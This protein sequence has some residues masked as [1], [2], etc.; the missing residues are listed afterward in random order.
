MVEEIGLNKRT[1]NR[2]PLDEL[3]HLSV[4]LLTGYTL[5]ENSTVVLNEDSEYI[6]GCAACAEYASGD[7]VELRTPK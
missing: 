4:Y 3:N 6:S 5:A 2:T 1:C 7:T